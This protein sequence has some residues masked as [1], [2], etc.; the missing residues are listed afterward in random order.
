MKK[1]SKLFLIMYLVV[2]LSVQVVPYAG[3]T[4]QATESDSTR[5]YDALQHCADYLIQTVPS[6]SNNPIGGEWTVIGLA[7]ANMLSEQMR[8]NYLV[9]LKQNMEACGGML[10]DTKYTEYS[11]VILALSA[12]NQDS[13]E[14]FGY[15]LLSY[16][17]DYDRVV[18]QGISGT[19]YALLA[20]DSRGYEIPMV[21]KAGANQTTR[22]KL[23]DDLLNHQLQDGGWTIAGTHSDS[24]VTAMVL[25]AL[26]PYQDTRSD[27][28][29][30]IEKALTCLSDMQL[31][32][33][34]FATG[35]AE[36]CESSAQVLT[37]LS[38]L[39]V[40]VT[41][42][43]FVKNGKTV[44]DALLEHQNADGSFLHIKGKQANMMATEQACYAL[45]AY[46]RFITGKNRLY[47]M[48]DSKTDVPDLHPTMSQAEFLSKV[49]ALSDTPT[50]AE[51]QSVRSLLAE[52]PEQGE[53][54]AKDAVS[55]KLNG[56]LSYLEQVKKQ[57]AKLDA[58]IWDRINPLCISMKDKDAVAALMQEYNSLADAN[59]TFVKNAD[60]LIKAD[61][62]IAGLEQGIWTAALLENAKTTKETLSYQG[63]LSKKASYTVRLLA[64]DI[65]ICQDAN[66]KLTREIEKKD[67]LPKGAKV[68]SFVKSGKLPG[69]V[70]VTIQDLVED[71]EYQLY[72][73][74]K[75]E[76]ILVKTVKVKKGVFSFETEK[77]SSYYLV[78]KQ[79]QAGDGQQT[80][81]TGQDTSGQDN[82]SNKTDHG[83]QESSAVSNQDGQGQNTQSQS[84]QKETAATSQPKKTV[85][86]LQMSGAKGL[87]KKQEKLTPDQVP[88]KKKTD[89]QSATTE[90]VQDASTNEAASAEKNQ[91]SFLE[92]G[93]Q[94][95]KKSEVKQIQDKDYNLHFSLTKADG[96]VYEYETVLNGQDIQRLMDVNLGLQ[97]SVEELEQIQMIS[98]S[99]FCIKTQAESLPGPIF[100]KTQTDLPDG[101]HL[102]CRYDAALQ[103][104]YYCDKVVVQD[105]KVQMILPQAGCYFLASAVDK[106]AILNPAEAGIVG[107]DMGSSPHSVTLRDIG[108]EMLR[109]DPA[110]FGGVFATMLIII[111]GVGLC[112]YRLKQN[113]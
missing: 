104:A 17:S 70:K 51:E 76:D 59:K 113:G 6:P 78:K 26:A 93:K 19:A 64:E 7:R 72:E 45:V 99:P 30:A 63:S 11:R 43:R 58:N 73:V 88:A 20:L 55:A 94:L 10:S 28:S 46:Q 9:N 112:I 96:A 3:M 107:T 5:V 80:E 61:G 25:T 42:V 2:F 75:K 49:Q 98:E 14:V 52:L 37:A 40:D 50:L 83:A 66:V 71:G 47:D 23:V 4:V 65:Q 100:V 32:H 82:T 89:S 36:T 84:G 81:G 48:T 39:A 38:S 29:Q 31:I 18:G 21:T 35:G 85:A 102:L 8:Q 41:D 69:T 22:E 109:E 90:K 62:I 110:I 79:T 97:F 54:V 74:E 44:L 111:V 15:P 87:S 77:A 91:T 101:E 57:V 67:T 12:L 1:K 86:N 13:K 68:F 56:A 60:D 16:M 108:L 53:F 103:G 92:N 24:D 106:N 33:G 34:G 105:G 27:V 95:Y